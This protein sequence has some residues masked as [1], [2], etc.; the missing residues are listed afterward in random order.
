MT[1]ELHWLVLTVL[2]TALLWVPYFL[3][4]VVTR[5]LWPAMQGTT[6][7][8][9]ERQSPWAL[10]A[11]KAH[12]NAVAN[13]ALFVPAVLV[14]HL[15]HLS[16][17]LTQTAVQV[18]FFARL[19]HYFVYAAGVPLGRTLTFTAGWA[20]LMAIVLSILGVL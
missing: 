6:P 14:A 17:S 2:M 4:R 9:G 19:L 13:L 3:D 7:E 15:L 8:T 1:V 12:E 18:Y 5:G 10:R 16:T 11:M 20:A